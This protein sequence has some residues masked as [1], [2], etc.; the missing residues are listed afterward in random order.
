MSNYLEVPKI[1][2][3]KDLDYLSDMFDWNLLSLKKCSE[4]VQYVEDEEIEELLQKGIDLFNN[5]LNLVLNIL[6]EENNDG[7]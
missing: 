1:L 4:S 5:N 2:T 6:S 3:C 7:E